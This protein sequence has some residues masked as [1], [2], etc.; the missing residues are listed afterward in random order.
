MVF[1]FGSVRDDSWAG[2]SLFAC[3]WDMLH[4]A[5]CCAKHAGKNPIQ[6]AWI[7]EKEGSFNYYYSN[8]VRCWAHHF[9]FLRFF[10]FF[11]FCLLFFVCVCLCCDRVLVPNNIH[12]SAWFTKA[13]GTEEED[14]VRHIEISTQNVGNAHNKSETDT[15]EYAQRHWIKCIWFKQI[16]PENHK[17]SAIVAMMCLAIYPASERNNKKVLCRMN[18][19]LWR[20]SRSHQVFRCWTTNNV[21]KLV[22][23]VHW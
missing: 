14:H 12:F 13:D 17:E 7:G 18:W 9:Y 6:W 1:Q 16:H 8:S 5:G 10:L 3:G 20:F 23:T 22:K 15:V 19:S 2:E 4:T 21:E 11:L